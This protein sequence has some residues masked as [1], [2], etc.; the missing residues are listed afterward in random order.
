MPTL[1]CVLPFRLLKDENNSHDI[2]NLGCYRDTPKCRGFSCQSTFHYVRI[3]ITYGDIR[4]VSVR[5]CQLIFYRY[6]CCMSPLCYHSTGITGARH[7]YVIMQ[8]ALPLFV[9]ICYYSTGIVVVRHHY[10]IL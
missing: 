2:L 1:K 7:H 8:Q 5:H 6:C 9:T 3:V 4:I 10:V